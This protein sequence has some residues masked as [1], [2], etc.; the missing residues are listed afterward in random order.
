MEMSRQTDVR[1]LCASRAVCGRLRR[2][3]KSPVRLAR[4]QEGDKVEGNYGGKGQ[5][6]PGRISHVSADGAVQRGLRRRRE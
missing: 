5:W 1:A 2:Y 4:L 3:G 6:Y